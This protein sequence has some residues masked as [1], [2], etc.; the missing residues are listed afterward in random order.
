MS[1]ASFS[2][3]PTEHE[4]SFLSKMRPFKGMWNGTVS[5]VLCFLQFLNTQF[6]VVGTKDL[7]SRLP[8]YASDWSDAWN[9]RCVEVRLDLTSD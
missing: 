3:A 6:V 7:R 5:S 4:P 8:Y 1:T 9:Y 2:S